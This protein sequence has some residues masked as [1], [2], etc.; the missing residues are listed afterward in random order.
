MRSRTSI[1]LV[2]LLVVGSGISV[3]EQPYDLPEWCSCEDYVYTF[4]AGASNGTVTV[5]PSLPLYPKGA[6]V[7]VDFTPNPGH[8]L[9][10]WTGD[11]NT[12][13]VPASINANTLILQVNGDTSVFA[14]GVPTT[15]MI[16]INWWDASRGNVMGLPTWPFETTIQRGDTTT[17][18]AIP[19]PGYRTVWQSVLPPGFGGVQ[20]ADSITV[21]GLDYSISNAPQEF[22]VS[23]L[24]IP[25]PPEP[26]YSITVNAQDGIADIFTAQSPFGGSHAGPYLTP[27]T[28]GPDWQLFAYRV[29]PSP[30]HA[31]TAVTW[32]ENGITKYSTLESLAGVSAGE[33]TAHLSKLATF[34]IEVVGQGVVSIENA[35]AAYNTR[36]LTGGMQAEPPWA[37]LP[38]P[39]PYDL[40]SNRVTLQASACAGWRF[41]RWEYHDGTEQ[42]GGDL[43]F[44]M[45]Y[46]PGPGKRLLEGTQA[47]RVK[48]VFV[49][50]YCDCAGPDGRDTLRAMYENESITDNQ[51]R[52]YA[53]RPACS[54]FV[55]DT[56]GHQYQYI[57]PGNLSFGELACNHGALPNSHCQWQLDGGVSALFQNVRDTYGSA[58]T[59]TNCYRCPI[60]NQSIGSAATSRHAYGQAFDFDNGSTSE[61]WDIA[62]AAL[63]GGEASAAGI[64][65]Y[66]SGQYLSLANLMA[67]GYDG[68][69]LPPGWQAYSHGH[70][71]TR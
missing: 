31:L 52:E 26:V 7:Q 24:P 65:L 69:N 32:D 11:L 28:T 30:L 1:L 18:T 47:V 58:I 3:A 9:L 42:E 49:E 68:Q 66:F 57:N 55:T 61:N 23:F 60:K 20:Y 15:R 25:P 16:K 10:Q 34:K 35:K 53:P 48:A 19:F 13:P 8:E 44:F 59:V 64:L 14:L 43:E 54:A 5:S 12:T 40:D 27:T 70:I 29:E 56:V 6:L 67:N 51:S 38:N 50:E 62:V 37:T 63:L 4:S 21:K 33:Y 46:W 71:D 39:L 22:I 45:D 41:D 36:P 17:L 2:S